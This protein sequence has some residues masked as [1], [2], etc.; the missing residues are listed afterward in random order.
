MVIKNSSLEDEPSELRSRL[1]TI[2]WDIW[3]RIQNQ[4]EKYREKV[5]MH[6]NVLLLFFKG[7]ADRFLERVSNDPQAI[8]IILLGFHL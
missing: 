2:A 4:G 7:V 8:S 5:C 3:D 1:A 6:L